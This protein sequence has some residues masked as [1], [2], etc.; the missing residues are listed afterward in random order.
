MS[1]IFRIL[2]L[3][4]FLV[5]TATPIAPTAAQDNAAAQVKMLN[6]GS[7]GQATVFEPEIIRVAPGTSADFIAEDFGHD[8]VAVAGLIPAGAE[9]FAGY[10]NA[11]LTVKFEKQGIYV[12]ECTAHQGAGMI[13]LVVVG[14][15]KANLDIIVANYRSN[16]KLSDKAKEKL[17]L[18]LERV[19]TGG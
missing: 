17:A 1:D 6:V 15:P 12:Y 8:A 10:K 7:T 2:A 19:K 3:I 16:P 14:D 5:G 11:D 18:L 9:A 13:G 4:V